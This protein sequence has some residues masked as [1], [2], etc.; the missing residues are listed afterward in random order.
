MWSSIE[1]RRPWAAATPAVRARAVLGCWLR[2]LRS[3][4]LKNQRPPRM[5]FEH[6]AALFVCW[7]M[8][9]P[10]AVAPSNPRFAHALIC[11]SCLA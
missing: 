10:R 9:G 7:V 3:R 2:R 5:A 6:A 8:S 11:Y 4:S 1:Q